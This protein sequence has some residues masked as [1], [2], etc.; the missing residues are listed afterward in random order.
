MDKIKHSNQ[1]F[2][3][4]IYANPFPKFKRMLSKIFAQGCMGVDPVEVRF[5]LVHGG[6]TQ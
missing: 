4:F 6:G 5:D 2:F 3:V 1:I